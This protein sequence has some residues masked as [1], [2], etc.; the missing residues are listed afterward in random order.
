MF[1]ILIA[2]FCMAFCFGLYAYAV[3]QNEI[4]FDGY[5]T[6]L[7]E[8][9]ESISSN[10]ETDSVYLLGKI[11]PYLIL[12][13]MASS[14]SMMFTRSVIP[15]MISL[16]GFVGFILSNQSPQNRLK[17]ELETMQEI[18]CIIGGMLCLIGLDRKSNSKVLL[19]ER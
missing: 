13:M 16:T 5:K 19:T 2:K 17:M 8:N 15:K 6:R 10:S 12:S 3:L 4:V 1:R 11:L 9:I 18:L 7:L 14:F